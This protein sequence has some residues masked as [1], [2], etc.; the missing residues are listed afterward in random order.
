M[1][2]RRER[3]LAIA[4]KEIGYAEKPINLTKYGEWFGL[5]GV[6]WC[7]IFCSWCYAQAGMMITKGGYLRGFAGCATIVAA[8]KDKIT[9]TPQPADLVIFDWNDDKAPD[10]VALFVRWIERGK[11]F[12]TIEGNTSVKNQSNG[13]QVMRRTRNIQDVHCFIN[14]IV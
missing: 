7:G 6:A 11:T 8:K 5:N 1:N 13:G 3:I 2:E 9:T 4:A 10:H 14:L 12:E